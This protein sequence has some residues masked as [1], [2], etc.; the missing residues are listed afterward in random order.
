MPQQLH[1]MPNRWR[2]SASVASGSERTSSISRSR[3]IFRTPGLP[4]FRGVVSPVSRRRCLTRLAQAGLTQNSVAICFVFMPRSDAASTRSRRSC[5]YGV[6]ILAPSCPV[7]GRGRKLRQRD[8]SRNP[9]KRQTR[10]AFCWAALELAS[11]PF[12]HR[13]PSGSIAAARRVP[14][15]RRAAAIV[16]HPAAAVVWRAAVGV[17]AGNGEAVE[18]RV[19][20]LAAH[21]LHDGA[22][23]DGPVHEDRLV[24]RPKDALE[25]IDVRHERGIS[26]S[27]IGPIECLRRTMDRRQFARNGPLLSPGRIRWGRCPSPPH[28]FQGKGNQ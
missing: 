18:H 24:G 5:E 4:I 3:S 27:F 25:L 6:A 11:E 22:D 15:H 7:P 23:L 14:C 8:G 28:T 17:A 19:R 26:P 2:S 9:N 12:A 16:E 1:S 13:A 20:P 21:A 10:Y